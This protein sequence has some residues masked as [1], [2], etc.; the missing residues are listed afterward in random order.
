M[1][2]MNALLRAGRT[3]WLY[4]VRHRARIPGKGIQVYL[5]PVRASPVDLRP[6]PA[7]RSISA[8]CCLSPLFAFHPVSLAF[9]LPSLA[10]FPRFF[11]F[12]AAK[13]DDTNAR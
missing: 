2:T 7:L 8:W 4:D 11:L 1:D 13:E 9:A 12:V 5:Q 6:I 10:L 3:L